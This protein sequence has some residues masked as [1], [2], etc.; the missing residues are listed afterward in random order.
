[1][2][3][4]DDPPT[5]LYGWPYMGGR[6]VLDPVPARQQVPPPVQTRHVRVIRVGSGWVA[7]WVG[8]EKP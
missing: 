6:T 3:D 1:M 7:C 4:P 5:T 8:E 2:T